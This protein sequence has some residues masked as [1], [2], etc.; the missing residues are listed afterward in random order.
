VKI[1]IIGGTGLISTGIT[2]QLVERG[3]HVTLYNRGK[4]TSEVG[5][6]VQRIT[7][8]RTDY[9]AFEAQIAQAEPFDTVIDMIAFKP[10]DVQSAIR[11]LRGRTSQYVFC[12]TVDV[13]TKPARHYPIREDAERKPSTAFPYALNKALCENILFDAHARGDLA[14]TSIRP[15][16]TYGE[17][18]SILHPLGWDPYFLDRLR[19]GKPVIVHGDGT[20]LWAPCHRDDVARAFVGAAGNASAFGKSYH[21]TSEEWLTWNAYVQTVAE[22]IGA[23]PPRLVHIPTDVL[24]RVLPKAAEWCAINFSFNNIFDNGAAHDDLGFRY[25]IPFIE[26]VHCVVSWLEA[27]GRLDQVQEP[28]FYDR[29]IQAWEHLGEAMV[30]ELAGLDA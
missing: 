30:Q 16:Y 6:G 27:H 26:G 14:V 8:D 29:V 17:G 20:S 28:P 15:A 1:L 3:D 23:P 2:R 10:E 22:A 24:A 13:Y 21:A 9:A 4:R 11:A 18:T 25:T 19:R 7:G 12:S 5:S